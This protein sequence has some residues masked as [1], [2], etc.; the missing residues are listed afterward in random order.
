MQ[1]FKD[2]E[3]APEFNEHDNISVRV[4]FVGRTSKLNQGNRESP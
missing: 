2:F 1:Y 3:S 4:M